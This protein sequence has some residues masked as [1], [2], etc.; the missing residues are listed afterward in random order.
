[1][2]RFILLI[3]FL[4]IYLTSFSQSTGA[5]TLTT[6]WT[7]ASGNQ[8]STL[9]AY[10]PT[11]YNSA[12][13]YSLIIGFPG[14]GY[15]YQEWGQQVLSSYGELREYMDS[16]YGN[17]IV[18]SPVAPSFPDPNGSYGNDALDYG[19][20]EA[21]TQKM[22][23]YY[24]IGDVYVQGFSVGGRIA[25]HQALH[26]AANIKGLIAHS[27][28][29]CDETIEFANSTGLLACTTANDQVGSDPNWGEKA[30]APGCYQNPNDVSQSFWGRANYVKDEINTYGGDAIY[31]VNPYVGHAVPSQTQVKQCWDHVSQ[32]ISTTDPVANFTASSTNIYVGESVTFTDASQEGSSALTSW[33]WTFEGGTP[34]SYTGQTPPAITYN[35]VGTYTVELTV[36]NS[37][38]YTDTKTVT[39]YITVSEEP[40]GAWIEQASGFSTPSRGITNFSIVDANTIWALAYDGSGNNANVQE[41]TKTTNGGDSWGPGT[42]DVGNSTLG[43]AMIHARSATKA[44][45]AAYK[46]NTGTQGIY[47]TTDGGSTWTR[48]TSADYQSSTSFTNVVY[49]WNDNDGF[50]MGDPVNGEFELYTTT[51]G[52]STWTAVN[53]DNIPNPLSGEYGYTGQY[54]AVGNDIWFTTNKGRLYHSSDKGY[55]WTVSQTPVSDFGGQTVSAVFDFKDSNNGI[56]IDNSGNV[57]KTTDGG[58]N[59]TSVSI[60]GNVFTLG[61]DWIDGTNTIFSAGG[62]P[63]GSSYSTDGGMTWTTIDSEQ[64]IGV[65]FLNENVGFSG[66]FN[67]DATTQGIWKWQPNT[68]TN[69]STTDLS[70]DIN[71]YPNPTKEKI[72]VTNVNNAYISIFDLSGRLLLSKSANSN[73]VIFNLSS[74]NTG[75]Y[76]LK[77]VNKNNVTV[78]KIIKK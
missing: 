10:V 76:I 53:G 78:R 66:Y 23:E 74:L 7:N 68:P 59:W 40:L 32:V 63:A 25:V 28:A 43:I 35:T 42:I 3:A 51:N 46:T 41:F 71:I 67:T 11:D 75:T 30:F 22:S 49:F 61:V 26:S 19:I 54:D 12:N 8:T 13:T 16:Y 38:G 48:Q 50:C 52:G 70:T 6:S 37:D 15:S 24:N 14:Q 2:N 60:T 34:S 77:I 69:V 47:V 39:N 17:V 72:T 44:Y 56:I 29:V 33:E 27:P 57:Y 55:T 9:Y 18:V 20:I 73:N 1:M 45:I 62:N 4:S 21:V 36:T 31:V 64:H 5:V 65:E 58:Q